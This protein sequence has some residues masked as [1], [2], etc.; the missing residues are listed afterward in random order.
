M[1][2][3]LIVPAVVGT[4][5]APIPEINELKKPDF[6][7]DL[8]AETDWCQHVCDVISVAQD[9]DQ[10]N[11]EPTGKVRDHVSWAAYHAHHQMD[12]DSQRVISTLL[13]LFP[14]DS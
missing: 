11:E 8:V 3:P 6:N 9:L 12:N 13:P 10:S 5:N 1:T 2:T 14:D 7:V 4:K